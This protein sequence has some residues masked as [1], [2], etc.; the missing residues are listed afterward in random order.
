MAVVKIMRARKMR[1]YPTS[2]QQKKIDITLGHC[3]YVYNKMLERNNKAYERRGEHLSYYSMQNLL[4]EMKEY[5]PWLK[6][7]DSQAL[8]QSCR[9]LNSAFDRFFKKKG[10]YPRFHSKRGVQSYR[11]TQTVSMSIACRKV[12]IPCLGWVKVSDKRDFDGRICYMT[13]SREAGKYYVSVTYETEIDVPEITINP[14]NMLGLDYKSD[15]LYMDSNGLCAEM[16]HY[17]REGQKTC[18]KLARCLSRKFGSHKGEKKSR[19]Y[20]KALHKLNKA[21]SHTANQRK[22]YLQKRSTE[23]ANQYDAVCVED[24]NLRAMA[25]KN[26]GNGKATNDNGYGMFLNMLEYKL[27]ARGKKLIRIDKWFPSSQLCHQC[28]YKQIMPL[29]VRTYRC[30][31][32]G[33]VCDRDYNAA[34]NIRAEGLRML[35]L[36]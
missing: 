10:G 13:V 8:Q 33:M 29:S 26:F 16:P 23:I 7:A 35:G 27:A 25:N 9:D 5:L 11:T 1:I 18:R 19:N 21:Q 2:E 20:I 12:K 24:L 6:D 28:G 31:N 17:Y 30:P 14:Y 3:R 15:G 4:P 22:D 32:C 34:L 36:A